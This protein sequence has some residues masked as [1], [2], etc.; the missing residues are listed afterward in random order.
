[1]KEFEINSNSLSYKWNSMLFWKLA[2]IGSSRWDNPLP[3]DFCTYWRHTLLW[4]PLVALA[5]LVLSVSGI[6]AVGALIYG[7]FTETL[8]FFATIGVVIAASATMFT[9]FFLGEKGYLDW[10]GTY[11]LFPL[12]KYVLRWPFVAIGTVFSF[13]FTKI[14]DLYEKLEEDRLKKAEDRGDIIVEKKRSGFFTML[15]MKYRAI[16]DRY[17]PM[18]TYTQ[19]EESETT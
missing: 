5:A 6:G 2:D 12:W 16:K 4:S 19:I 8:T 13:I 15:Y 9:L 7:A 10:I 3:R 11:F 18:V 1:M 17:C 14:F